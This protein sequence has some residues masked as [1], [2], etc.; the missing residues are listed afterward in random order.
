MEF[1]ESLV[2]TQCALSITKAAMLFLYTGVLIIS[3]NAKLSSSSSG[4]M[5][6]KENW[7]L[8]IFSTSMNAAAKSLLLS[9]AT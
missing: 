3:L 9:E 7:P 5:N 2:G 8:H 1:S 6:S 4:L